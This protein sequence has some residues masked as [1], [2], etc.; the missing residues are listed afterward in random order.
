MVEETSVKTPTI[1]NK[2]TLVGY[3]AANSLAITIH[4][5][6]KV[7]PLVSHIVERG[8]NDYRSLVFL[9][10]DEAVEKD[11]LRVNAVQNALHRATL[12][13]HGASM[14]LGRLLAIEP[15]A[16]RYD[17]ADL[18]FQRSIRP[19]TEP[20]PLPVEPGTQTLTVNV[21]ATWELV[22]E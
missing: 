21:T 20:V 17:A 3:R 7:G 6:D 5:L 8:A 4:Q 13:A 12:Y 9:I 18:P 15:E 10:A 11:K 16:D 2:R 14:K 22:P 1:I 19:A